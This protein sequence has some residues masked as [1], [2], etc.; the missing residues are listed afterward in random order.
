MIFRLADLVDVSRLRTDSTDDGP[1]YVSSRYRS[2]TRPKHNGIDIRAPMMT[3]IL[4]PADGCKVVDTFEGARN[5][6][7][8]SVNVKGFRMT[9]IHLAARAPGVFEGA[10]L[11]KGQLIGW[12]GN[13][14]A[15]RGPHIHLTLRKYEDGDGDGHYERILVDPLL[16]IGWP[17]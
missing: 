2:P 1:R 13:T 3:P 8:V 6:V 15:S 17:T 11:L 10:K 16:H 7:G 9:L 12:S 14:G 5:G 4:A